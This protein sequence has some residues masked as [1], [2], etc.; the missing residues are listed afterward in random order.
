VLSAKLAE[1]LRRLADVTELKLSLIT[2]L[3]L[4]SNQSAAAV[5]RNPHVVT[6]DENVAR[7]AD[8]IDRLEPMG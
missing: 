3:F 2:F 6:M 8:L 1:L 4:F 5:Q 7:A